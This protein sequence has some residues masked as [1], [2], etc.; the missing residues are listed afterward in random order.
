[1][2]DLGRFFNIDP[3]AESYAYNSPFAFQ[4]NKMG[5]GRE[6]EGLELIPRNPTASFGGWF[7]SKYDSAVSSM[8]STVS[9]IMSSL[10]V[11]KTTTSSSKSAGNSSGGI[12]FSDGGNNQNPSALPKGGRDVP[13]ID[14][15]GSLEVMTTIAAFELNVNFAPIGK[16]TNGG[17]AT[18]ENKADDGITAVDNSINAGKAINDAVKEK[19]KKAPK[20]QDSVTVLSYSKKGDLTNEERKAK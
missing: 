2:P 10:S 13:W 1:M 18:I 4:E 12:A 7:S 14:F 3:L 19:E 11:G 15:G 9:N 17:K 5:M 16:G 20:E 6:L 8:Q